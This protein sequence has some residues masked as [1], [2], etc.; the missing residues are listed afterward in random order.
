MKA[1]S[2]TEVKNRL[3]SYIR[4]VSRGGEDIVIESHGRPSA[5]LLSYEVCRELREL[6]E[7]HRRREA[8]E[9]L[10]RLRDEVRA[11][12]QDLTADKADAIADEIADEAM[13]RVIARARLRWSGRPS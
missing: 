13:D 6:Q 12:N 1:V 8:M 11:R 5:V 2:A 10:W 4:E 3:D 7:Q 9:A